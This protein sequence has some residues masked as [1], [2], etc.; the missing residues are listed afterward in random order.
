MNLYIIIGILCV[1]FIIV[2][3]IIY[4]LINKREKTHNLHSKEYRAEI[5]NNTPIEYKESI[6]HLYNRLEQLDKI[7]D[8]SNKSLNAQSTQV[9][10]DI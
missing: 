9:V 8:R 5:Y 4:H 10:N 1:V 7:V 3:C 2:I 6:R